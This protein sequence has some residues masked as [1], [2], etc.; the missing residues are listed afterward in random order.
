V[1][2]LEALDAALAWRAAEPDEYPITLDLRRR[3][4]AEWGRG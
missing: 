4:P 3:R 2:D 1:V